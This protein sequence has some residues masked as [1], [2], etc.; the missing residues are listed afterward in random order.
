MTTSLTNLQHYNAEGNDFLLHIVTS[1]EMFMDHHRPEIKMKSMVWKQFTS[2]AKETFT[3]T[4]SKR[5]VIAI[6]F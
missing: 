2:P 5:M 6:S 4:V 1:N 3:T